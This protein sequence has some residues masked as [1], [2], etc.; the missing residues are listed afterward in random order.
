M[1]DEP[2]KLT[3]RDEL[4]PLVTWLLIIDAVTVAAL[5]VLA[6]VITSPF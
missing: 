5:T 1:T 4:S 3:I 6:F 2:E